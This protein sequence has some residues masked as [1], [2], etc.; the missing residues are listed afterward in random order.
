MCK[1][2]EKMSRNK[3]I[4]VVLFVFWL[5]ITNSDYTDS[6]EFDNKNGI[7]KPSLSNIYRLSMSKESRKST[8]N[9]QFKP[10]LI[11]KK[12]QLFPCVPF[13]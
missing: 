9:E 12:K 10:I 6:K 5:L 11:Y 13:F 1:K 2:M 4:K 7:F 8:I 3:N